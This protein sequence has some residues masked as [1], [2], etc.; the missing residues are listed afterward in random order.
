MSSS[1]LKDVCSSYTSMSSRILQ[2]INTVSWNAAA[3]QCDY[4]PHGPSNYVIRWRE[5]S[6]KSMSIARSCL[7]SSVSL[8]RHSMKSLRPPCGPSSQM[9][10]QSLGNR[11]SRC[12]RPAEKQRL[13]CIEIFPKYCITKKWKNLSLLTGEDLE[14]YLCKCGQSGLV[15]HTDPAHFLN[16]GWV[17]PFPSNWFEDV[18]DRR[19][20]LKCPLKEICRGPSTYQQL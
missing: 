16:L 14:S 3:V 17:H 4:A 6:Q 13:N 19:R 2:H 9:K 10:A 11:S 7:D 12:V 5:Q 1:I 18:P 8:F 20:L 15:E